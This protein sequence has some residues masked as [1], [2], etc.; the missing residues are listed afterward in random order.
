[1][2]FYVKSPWFIIEA[3]LERISYHL[4]A[5]SIFLIPRYPG[6]SAF[7]DDISYVFFHL[8]NVELK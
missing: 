4:Q 3:D 6:M 7:L 2:M 5:L 1:M 8:H